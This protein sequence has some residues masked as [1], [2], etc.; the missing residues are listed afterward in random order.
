VEGDP[1][2]N[3]SHVRRTVWAMKDGARYDAAALY[4]SVGVT[5]STR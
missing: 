3:I 4:K 1:S 2:Q 5:H